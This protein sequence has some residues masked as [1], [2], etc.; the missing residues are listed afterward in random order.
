[1]DRANIRVIQCGRSFGFALETSQGLIVLDYFIGQKFEGDKAMK[2]G[3][4]SFV[5]HTHSA[6]TEFLQNAVV[7]DGGVDHFEGESYVDGKGQVN[8]T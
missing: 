3:V 4:F 1:V 7:R 5:D 8:D 6:A 2:A